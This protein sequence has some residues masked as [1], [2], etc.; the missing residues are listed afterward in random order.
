MGNKWK[1]IWNNRTIQF[2]ISE[3]GNDEFKIYSEL[4]KLDGFDV[5]I[6][7]SE[8]Y[9]RKFYD[10]AMEMCEKITQNKEI[11]SVFEVGCGSGANLYLLKNRNLKVGGV[12][13]SEILVDVANEILGENSVEMGE[14]AVI[15]VSEKYDIVLC[16][17][18]FAY[19]PDE[20]YGA[21]VLEKM[22]EKAKKGI[23]ISE[24]FDK[25]L[26]D[27]CNR[28]RKAMIENYD[29]K[30]KGLDKIFYSRDL[31]VNFA[32]EHNCRID[33]SDVTNEYYWN[34]R[35]LFNCFLYKK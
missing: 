3:L 28:H 21:K 16:D 18:V 31:F 34:S 13:Y 15:D 9:Y 25:D 27:E 1:E 24:I 6:E 10:T 12:D 19:F 17:S 32:N 20:E 35:Y 2:K 29:E 22:Y 7:D 33:F 4:K 30:Y 26:E 23:F 8:A 5:S 11:K 14:A